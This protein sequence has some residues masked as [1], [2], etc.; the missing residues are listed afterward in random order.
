MVERARRWLPAIAVAIG[1][2]GGYA[3]ERRLLRA[4]LEATRAP[5]DQLGTIGGVLEELRGPDGTR[6]AVETYGPPDA[7]TV[8]LAH[9]WTC[10]GRVW[11]EQVVGLADRYRLVTYDQPG[12]GRSSGPRSGVYDLDLLG[13]TLLAVIEHTT[14]TGPLVLAGH[15]LGGM[16]VLNAVGRHHGALTDRLAGVALLSTTSRARPEGVALGL[17]IHGA[18]RLEAAI[19]RLVPLFGHPRVQGVTNRVYSSST[20]LSFLLTRA[21]GL[22]PDADARHVDLT[23]QLI[24]DADPEM[25]AGLTPTVLT[26]DEDA[27]WACLD[28]PTTILVGDRDRLTPAA[29]SQHMAARCTQAEL[30]RLPR[31]GHMTQLE[32]ADEVNAVL[33]HHLERARAAAVA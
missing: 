20:D 6:I 22:G 16:T 7:P 25:I 23:E 13:D 8:V 32:A 21:L 30:R 12:H 4:R 1:A 17:G 28:V 26:V 18:A 31:V 10:T 14:P 15:S 24:L 2:T 9:G 29:L 5:G 27:A 3:A 33:A 19:R 11:H